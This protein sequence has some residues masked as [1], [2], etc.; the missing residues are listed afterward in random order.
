MWRV[1]DRA[2]T[3]N[4]ST[5]EKGRSA[6]AGGKPG[7]RHAVGA[8]APGHPRN[9]AARRRA[10][11]GVEARAQGWTWRRVAEEFG[12]ASPGH[13]YS[14]VMKSLTRDHPPVAVREALRLEMDA[15]IDQGL[16]AF[17]PKMI[18]GEVEAARVVVRL[19][20]R[21]SKLLGLDALR[22]ESYIRLDSVQGLLQVIFD[23][24]LRLIAPEQH[25]AFL[26]D[27][28]RT[29]ALLGPEPRY[30]A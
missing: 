22:D 2:R 30:A 21:R 3:K 17:I 26:A 27:A 14:E 20:E 16:S 10:A 24:A 12:Y 5:T 1:S 18:E 19:L 13:A 28:E 6:E 8:R 25:R 29:L 7:K 23:S 4:L 9:V 15:Q 11:K